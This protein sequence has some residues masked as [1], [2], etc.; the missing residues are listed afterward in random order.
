MLSL[1]AKTG[2]NS[3]IN[4]NRAPEPGEIFFASNLQVNPTAEKDEN[5]NNL[6]YKTNHSP[7]HVRCTR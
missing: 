5:D 4:G 2:D 6:Q 7:V 3:D 1:I